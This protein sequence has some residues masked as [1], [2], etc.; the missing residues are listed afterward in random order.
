MKF[1]ESALA[2]KYLDGLS[3]IEIGGAAHNPFGLNTL[4]IDL[5]DSMDS[6]YKQLERR[7]CDEAMPV[8]IVAF[9][10]EL[11]LADESQ[12]F[13][14]SSHV[15][16]HFTDPI[17]ALIEWHRVIKKGGYIFMIVPHRDR[18][19]DSHKERTALAEIIERHATGR[20]AGAQGQCCYRLRVARGELSER[21]ASWKCPE[22]VGEHCSVWITDDVVEIVN[23]LGWK[24]V[25]VQDAD[26]K[27]GNGFTVMIQK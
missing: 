10:D 17:H 11:P 9:G 1:P 2:H 19:P 16:E 7:F 3:G 23:Y 15:L 5:S 21:P 18:T 12:D 27:V 25:D 8:D 14:I 20:C 24:I 26:D 6:A 4:N 22:T 13:V